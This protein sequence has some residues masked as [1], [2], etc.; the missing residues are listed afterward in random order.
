M[1]KIL[2]VGS[3][4]QIKF[5]NQRL[6]K[7]IISFIS[8][9]QAEVVPHTDNYD[10]LIDYV[11][12]NPNSIIL[13]CPTRIPKNIKRKL[14]QNI[15]KTRMILSENNVIIGYLRLDEY[16]I[17]KIVRCFDFSGKL[18]HSKFPRKFKSEYQNKNFRYSKAH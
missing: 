3:A 13:F 4:A 7:D 1:K 5:G 10:V 17:Q 12:N 16:R 6:N 8:E 2:I 18:D 11:E 14:S 15:I 9:A